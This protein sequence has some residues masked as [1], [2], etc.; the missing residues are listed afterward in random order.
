MIHR[1]VLETGDE[2]LSI[3]RQ[4]YD[5]LK[6]FSLAGLVSTK[7]GPAK[8]L[9]VK[10]TNFKC[11]WGGPKCS[12]SDLIDW[13]SSQRD[14]CSTSLQTN[15][16]IN[17][18]AAMAADAIADIAKWLHP[19]KSDGGKSDERHFRSLA[20]T[21]REAMIAQLYRGDNG[22]GYFVDGLNTEHSSVHATAWAAAAGV[23]EQQQSA[24]MAKA[25]TATIRAK[26][27]RCSCMGA[28]WLLQGLYS[29]AVFDGDAAAYALQLLTASNSRSWVNMMVQGATATMEAWTPSDKENLS[30]S[31]PWCSAPVNVIPRLLMGVQPT[32]PSWV[33]FSVTPQP[34]PLQR[35]SLDLRV[36]K[37]AIL[38]SFE[39][40]AR[41]F[42]L[43]LTVPPGTSAAQVCLPPPAAASGASG[44]LVVDG[45]IVG[46][47]VKR[48]RLLCTVSQLTPGEHSVIYQA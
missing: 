3:A 40:S 38:V 25:M 29:L 47:P 2:G 23:V 33:T 27:M 36:P 41:V 44:A 43:R 13:P 1:M 17:S 8:G 15:T 48:G 14:G 26:G 45:G 37:G 28:H 16:V 39:Q 11:D 34:G 7:E 24:T 4:Y 30:W 42:S 6:Q 21:I 20:S 12:A 9:V 31:H 18:Y 22:T 46:T 10:P 35:G 5:T 32:A 19:S